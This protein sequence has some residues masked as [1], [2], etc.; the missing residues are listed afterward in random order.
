M[1]GPLHCCQ[2]PVTETNSEQMPRHL[3]TTGILVA[4][5]IVCAATLVGCQ[6]PGT[7]IPQAG[8]AFNTVTVDGAWCWFADPRAVY[9]TLAGK[10]YVGWVD[11]TAGT[12]SIMSY[13]HATNATV[14]API[15]NL[16]RDDHANPAL[17]IRPNGRI[18]AFYS[19]HNGPEMYYRRT[20]RPHDLSA[21]EPAQTIGGPL[22]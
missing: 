3:E 2:I 14:N 5:V 1:L 19:A 11:S 10:T 4:G 12:V 17:L 6:R 21:W 18:M 16:H 22:G 13:D 7:T 9:D 20:S 8:E 15:A